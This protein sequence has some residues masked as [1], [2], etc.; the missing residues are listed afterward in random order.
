MDRLEYGVLLRTAAELHERT[1][2]MEIN[3]SRWTPP[4]THVYVL[5]REVLVSEM[6]SI[7]SPCADCRHSVFSHGLQES[8]HFDGFGCGRCIVEMAFSNRP[9]CCTIYRPKLQG[10]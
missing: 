6:P 2:K 4:G 3:L 1:L 8:G 9:D 5:C 10:T 7:V